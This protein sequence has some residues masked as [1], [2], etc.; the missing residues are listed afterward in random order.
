MRGS[1]SLRHF[2][3]RNQ[4]KKIKVF[5]LDDGRE[6]ISNINKRFL[7]DHGIEKQTSIPYRPQQDGVVE[8]ANHTIMEMTRNMLYS[9]NFF[10]LF[11]MK[12]VANAVYTLNQC[13][14]RMLD[15]ITNEKA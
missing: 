4:I 9:Q 8:C 3:R 11:W 6:F 13:P 15:L 5:Q 10:K 14:T 2:K 1:K 12:V 7:K